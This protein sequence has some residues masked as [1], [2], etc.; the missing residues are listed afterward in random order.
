MFE[1]IIS[2]S[3]NNKLVVALGVI[4]LII[5]GVVSFRD[6]P[7]DAV[8]DITNNQV[9]V[10]TLAPSLAP[11]EVERIIT[12]P[13]ELTLASIPGITEQR[14]ISRFGLSVI[15]LVFDDDV[16]VY[17]ARAQVDQRLIEVQSQIPQGTATPMLAPITTG[18]GE[19]F[20]YTLRVKQ[21]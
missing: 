2:F 11:Q 10:V 9:Q 3:V 15:T 19:I 7:I 8:P 20:Q 21:G 16:D 17:W 13:I 4:A 12:M 14:S 1:R 5:W 18:L 6:L